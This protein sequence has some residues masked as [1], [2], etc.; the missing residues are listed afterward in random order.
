MVRELAV[1]CPTEKNDGVSQ[2]D[3][4]GAGACHQLAGKLCRILALIT[5]YEMINI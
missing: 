3:M 5:E 2:G 1:W 4:C